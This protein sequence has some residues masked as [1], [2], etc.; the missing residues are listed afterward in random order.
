MQSSIEFGYENEF[1][2]G[3]STSVITG[4][5]IHLNKGRSQQFEVGWH[6]LKQS[7]SPPPNDQKR[8]PLAGGRER[9]PAT[10]SHTPWPW[11]RSQKT[12]IIT[13]DRIEV[14]ELGTAD[15]Q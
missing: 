13:G 7:F 5:G 8:L 2:C 11:L 15:A 3:G 9:K 14:G 10:G 1:R 4:T 12:P 6:K